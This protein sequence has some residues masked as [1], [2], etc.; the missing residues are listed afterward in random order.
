MALSGPVERDL[1]PAQP[2]RVREQ[3][4]Q[5]AAQRQVQVKPQQ[6]AVLQFS[7]RQAWAWAWWPR[8]FGLS[9]SAESWERRPIPQQQ[10]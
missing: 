2:A 4:Q 9:V 1:R 6:D 3:P 5:G 10:G 8:I 7:R